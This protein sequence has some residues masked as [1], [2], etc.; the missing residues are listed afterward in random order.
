MGK[1]INEK[2]FDDGTQLKLSIIRE[3]FREWLPVFEHEKNTKNLL[4]CDLFAGSGCDI[5]GSPGSPIIFLDETVGKTSKS[6]STLVKNGKKVHL[7]LNEKKNNKYQKLQ[8]SVENKLA[9]CRSSC[10]EQ[11][12]PIITHIENKDFTDI[13][14]EPHFLNLMN[15]REWAKFILL[16]QYG[17]RYVDDATF[18]KLI[19]FPK[20][21]FIFFITSSNLRRFANQPVVTK[22]FDIEPGCLKNE[23]SI[24]VHREIVNHFRNLIPRDIEYYLHGFT[25]KKAANYWGLIFGSSHSYGMEK[26]LNVCWKKDV[27]SGDSNLNID[28]DIPPDDF[29]FEPEHTSKKEKTRA[30]LEEKIIKKEITN[31]I[32]GMKFTLKMGCLPKIFVDTVKY[33]MASNKISVDSKFNRTA[34]RIHKAEKYNIIVK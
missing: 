22:H 29:F 30:L 34:T 16:D 33:L 6:C 10:N 32:D 13:I 1:D 21:D 28:R 23:K 15:S 17:F 14:K 27:T 26:F 25:I 3:C 31:N 8:K 24:Y 2:P 12:C 11:H 9:A 7:F 20:T 19:A 5:E 18:L 4:V